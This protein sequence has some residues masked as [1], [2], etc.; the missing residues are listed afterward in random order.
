MEALSRLIDKASGVGLLSGFPVGREAIDPLKISHLLF[1]DDTLIFCEANPDSLTYLRVMLTCFEATSGLRVNLGKSE[2]VQVG[3]MPHLEELADI[4]GCKTATLP[5]KYL[6]L[7]L[8][9]HFK[10]QSI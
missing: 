2:L 3:E 8:G 5:M 9:A 1:A 10:V 6:G 7:P 4:L